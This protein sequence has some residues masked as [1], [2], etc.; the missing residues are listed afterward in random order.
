MNK[1][2][3]I[4]FF[5]KAFVI[6]AK[7]IIREEN[8]P[9]NNIEWNSVLFSYSQYGE[10]LQIFNALYSLNKREKAFYVDVGCYHPVKYSN[11]FKLHKI[12]WSGINIDPVP[13]NISVFKEFRPSDTNLQIAIS[14]KN[15][16]EKFHCY[17]AGTTN[18]LDSASNDD[19]FSLLNEK[20]YN[21]F[22]VKTLTLAATLEKY[23][24]DDLPFGVLSI[25]C[26]GHEMN[27]LK[28]SD[29]SKY[30]PWIVVVED[31]DFS[32]TSEISKFMHNKGY[33]TY[34]ITN[35][36]KIFIDKMLPK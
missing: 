35:V 5:F 18:R 13:Y 6:L 19:N 28:S 10:D 26:E 25:D 31:F 11:T 36:T 23:A 7:R 33:Q 32:E 22:N 8:I 21:S 2:T 3:K 12:G 17:P 14:S 30:R 34:F 27:I 20:P 9:L 16:I 1:I 24:P 15:G 29:W 4:I